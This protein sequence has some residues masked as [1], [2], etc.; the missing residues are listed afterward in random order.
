M[1]KKNKSSAWCQ[2]KYLSRKGMKIRNIEAKKKRF[3]LLARTPWIKRSSVWTWKRNAMRKRQFPPLGIVWKG[4]TKTRGDKTQIVTWWKQGKG[5]A[6]KTSSKRLRFFLI[7][8]C[9]ELCAEI[10]NG[11]ALVYGNPNVVGQGQ[12][13]SNPG[14]AG[15][16][17]SF[18]FSLSFAAIHISGSEGSF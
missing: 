3:I 5:N 9:L 13:S 4:E 8:C 15:F 10:F 16:R 1:K 7:C 11:C 2:E 6:A 18:N 12:W 17:N 14:N